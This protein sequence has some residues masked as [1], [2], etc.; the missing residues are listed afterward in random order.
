MDEAIAL[1]EEIG[2]GI[3][4]DGEMRRFSFQS[5]MAEAVEGFGEFDGDAF[6]WGEWS[7][8]EKVGDWSCKRPALLGVRSKLTR[9]R[10]LSAE[11]FT[12]LR[13]GTTEHPRSV[14]PAP[15]YGP[16][17]GHG[18]IPQTPIPLWSIFCPMSSIFLKKKFGNWR[19]LELATSSS[20]L[21]TMHCFSMRG[22]GFSTRVWD[23]PSTGG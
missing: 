8:D 3:L 2:L 19:V 1:Q 15:A 7:G 9:K 17:F 22:P 11:E 21:L 5:Q 6:L 20:M 12:Y 14:S 10:H 23:G 16:T 18:S 13:A 4:T